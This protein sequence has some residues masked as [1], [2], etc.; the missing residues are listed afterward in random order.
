L[1]LLVGLLMLAMLWPL[2]RLPGHLKTM[3]QL[4]KPEAHDVFGTPLTEQQAPALWARVRSLARRL[5]AM[6]PDNIV[7]GCLE[8]FYVTSADVLLQ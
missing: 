4:F 5:D 1:Q 3:L 2:Y 6:A 7:V 8:G